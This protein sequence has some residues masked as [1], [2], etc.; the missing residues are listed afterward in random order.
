M[1]KILSLNILIVTI[2]V[3]L[4][5]AGFGKKVGGGIIKVT[6]LAPEKR[7]EEKRDLLLPDM[8]VTKPRQIYISN[9]GV[10][11]VIRFSTTFIN[12]GDGALEI[13][14]H[15]DEDSEKT[16]AT[17]YIY[18]NNGSGMYHDIGSFVLHPTHD[19]WHVED[20]VFY[21]LIKTNDKTETPIA[22]TN[23]MSF[24]IWDEDNERLDI[25]NAINRQAYPR[26]CNS[27]RQGMS[28]G[29][30]DT[31]TASTDGQEMD[32]TDISDGEYIFR[33]IVNPDKKI[34]ELD[35]SNNTS[36]IIITIQGNNL[37]IVE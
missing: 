14:G 1:K 17:Q 13:I 2:I 11:K 10:K 20:Y 21:Q 3:I 33:S 26:S 18:E 6:R 4:L 9:N 22:Q 5:I 12:Q 7:L 8:I 23:K 31:Y 24:C 30:S 35:Y 16:W 36:E 32:I 37:E 28:V 19:H 29:W 15:R 34:M 25:A 27:L